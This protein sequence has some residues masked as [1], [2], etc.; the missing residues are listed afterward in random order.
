MNRLR[1]ESNAQ[2][3]GRSPRRARAF[4]V[5]L[6]PR[7]AQLLCTAKNPV[8]QLKLAILLG[9]GIGSR[10]NLH[11]LQFLEDGFH[12][13]SRIPQKFRTANA[14]EGPP[15]AFEH[16]L[17]LQF[18][19]KLFERTITVAITLDRQAIATTLDHQV[20]AVGSDSPVR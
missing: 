6:G 9:R 1:P 16:G 19:W 13:T 10:R 17:T 14:R 4:R 5:R 8:D 15:H 7:L 18:F 11:L 20:E 12:G 2:G 3:H